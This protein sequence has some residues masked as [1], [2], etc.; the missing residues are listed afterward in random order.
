MSAPTCGA[1]GGCPLPPDHV[2]GRDDVLGN[3]FPPGPA[4][5]ALVTAAARSMDTHVVDYAHRRR[6]DAPTNENLARTV[7]LGLMADPV[8]LY[9]AMAETGALHRE[10][11]SAWQ[12]RRGPEQAEPF[13]PTLEGERVEHRWATGWYP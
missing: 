6:D 5:D 1:F 13:E 12:G 2:T 8:P 9:E 10:W 3:H 4:F 7:L 11:S